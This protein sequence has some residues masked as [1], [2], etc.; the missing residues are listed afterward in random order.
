MH[1]VHLRRAGVRPLAAALALVVGSAMSARTADAQ[2]PRTTPDYTLKLPE[3]E[4]YHI[5]SASDPVRAGSDV[6]IAIGIRN[7]GTASGTFDVAIGPKDRSAVWGVGN[8]AT[9]SP[10][11]STIAAVR[12]TYIQAMHYFQ[13]TLAANN[14]GGVQ[15]VCFG[16]FLLRDGTKDLFTDANNSNHQKTHCLKFEF[17]IP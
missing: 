4:I 7:N 12:M 8:G 17:P 13:S 1:P 5:K 9:L 10:G 14:P 3:L 6:G 16:V 2:L 11:K 15:T